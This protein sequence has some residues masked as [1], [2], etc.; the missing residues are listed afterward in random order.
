MDMNHLLAAADAVVSLDD[1]ID[2]RQAAARKARAPYQMMRPSPKPKG[3]AIALPPPATEPSNLPTSTTPD[4]SVLQQATEQTV[5]VANLEAMQKLVPKEESPDVRIMDVKLT[6][7]RPAEAEP[8]SQP[9]AKRGRSGR[10]YNEPPIWARLSRKN[11][12]Y[13]EQVRKYP[14]TAQSHQQQRVPP[15]AQPAITPRANGHHQPGP[16]VNGQT[17]VNGHLPA[18]D[19]YLPPG[20]EGNRPWLENPPLDH[21]LLR[22][23]H[24][25]RRPKWEKTIEYTMPVPDMQRALTDWFEMQLSQ[26]SDITT[27]ER[28]VEIEIEGKIGQI[29][30]DEQRLGLPIAVPTIVGP[31]WI[32]TK[33]HFESKM[34]EGQHAA[35]NK[36][37]NRT[38]EAANPTAS[39]GRGREP[40][41]H[42]HTKQIDSFQPLSAAGFQALPESFR[43][44]VHNRSDLK[45]RTTVDKASGKTLAR[46]VKHKIADLHIYNPQ[47]VYDCRISL[48]LEA[49]LMPPPLDPNPPDELLALPSAAEMVEPSAK[50]SP[51]RE[52]DRLSYNHMDV[53]QIDL[54]KVESKSGVGI[55]GETAYE[56]E[57]EVKAGVL[58]EQ[59]GLKFGGHVHGFDGVVAGFLGNA[60]VLMRE[61]G[62]R[63]S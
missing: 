8:V 14:S 45:L 18:D 16:P 53:Y 44:H 3:Q 42:T 52:K 41:I 6:H 63:K 26:L 35:M 33:C 12:R 61:G 23:R 51:D 21:D 17:Q 34:A 57:L 5:P 31:D 22:V 2:G 54:T 59:M 11:P 55:R 24:A 58:R 48:N 60:M 28:V 15:A 56:L 30:I 32:K 10:K 43:R 39:S 38:T 1:A 47:G 4:R 20:I 25:T 19:N 13:D 62:A 27:D 37:L 29:L 40:I 7:K 49:K 36:F 46:I 9:A 50:P